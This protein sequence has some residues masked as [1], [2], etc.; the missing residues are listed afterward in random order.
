MNS[1]L[2]VSDFAGALTARTDEYF[3]RDVVT[4]DDPEKLQRAVRLEA[5]RHG[6]QDRVARLNQRLAEV[7]DES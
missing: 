4:C 5:E 1:E 6:R 7:R 2:S 3:R